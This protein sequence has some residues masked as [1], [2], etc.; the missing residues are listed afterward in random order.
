M[1]ST[2][3]NPKP[4]A[5]ALIESALAAIEQVLARAA[6]DQQERLRQ[7]KRLVAHTKIAGRAAY[8][9]ALILTDSQSALRQEVDRMA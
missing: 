3:M 6:A 2:T 8:R 9:A 1:P 7:A 4:N 5:S